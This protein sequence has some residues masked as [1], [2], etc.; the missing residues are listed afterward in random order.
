MRQ[1]HLDQQKRTAAARRSVFCRLLPYNRPVH[2]AI[3]GL[4][5]CLLNGM[6]Q[7]AFGYIFARLLNDL[8]KPDREG[9]QKGTIP[10]DD[11]KVKVYQICGLAGLCFLFSVGSKLCIGK[12]T[13]NVTLHLRQALYQ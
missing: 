9:Q 4:L 5:C 3:L 2:F 12:L 7:P 13:A 8:L 6:A 11:I 10:I 1:G